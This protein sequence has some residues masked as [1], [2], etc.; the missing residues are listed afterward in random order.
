[1]AHTKT[2]TVKATK[3]QFRTDWFNGNFIQAFRN[4]G[5]LAKLFSQDHPKGGTLQEDDTSI[6]IQVIVKRVQYDIIAEEVDD[7]NLEIVARG[8]LSKAGNIQKWVLLALSVVTC[9]G[10]IPWSIVFF[11]VQPKAIGKVIDTFIG[12]F[13]EHYIIR[14]A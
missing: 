13:E 9:V 7:D 1:M 12:G 11:L 8:D 2:T 10:L 14:E 5:G 6:T 3:D 4:Q